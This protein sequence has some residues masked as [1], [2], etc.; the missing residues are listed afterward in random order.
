[1]LLSIRL[2]AC[3][4]D[5]GYHC[6]RAAKFFGMT[7]LAVR[8][9]PELSEGDEVIDECFGTDDIPTVMSESDYVVVATPLTKSTVGLIGKKEL[10]VAKE[11]QVLI[12]ISRGAVMDEEAL[13]EALQSGERIKGAALDVFCTEPLPKSSP[14]W[15]VPNLL[16]SP[17]NAD[18]TVSFR[19][20]SIKHFTLNCHRF[21]GGEE[22]ESIVD[23]ECGY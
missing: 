12:N 17:H 11:G 4:V 21:V 2:C 6:A 5:I 13:I 19:H 1:M 7:V 15:N 14:F 20:Q 23:K 9:R 22:L 3:G 18:M 8:R 16:L 10:A